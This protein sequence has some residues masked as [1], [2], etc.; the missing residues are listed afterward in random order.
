MTSLLGKDIELDAIG[1]QFDP[2]FTGRVRIG[3]HGNFLSG[4]AYCHKIRLPVSTTFLPDCNT[5]AVRNSSII[6]AA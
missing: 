1:R 5:I 2:Y 6:S 3:S 4:I